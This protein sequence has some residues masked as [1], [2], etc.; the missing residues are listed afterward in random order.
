[1]RKN[2]NKISFTNLIQLTAIVLLCWGCGIFS[3]DKKFAYK[4]MSQITRIEITGDSSMSI[5]E[6]INNKWLVNGEYPANKDMM[7]NLTLVLSK[8]K[9]EYPLP[10]VYAQTLTD[11]L[12]IEKGMHIKLYAKTNLK[13]DFYILSSDSLGCIGLIN[14]EQQAY[15]LHMPGYNINL[16]DYIAPN[17]MFWLNNVL[18]SYYRNDI[19]SVEV[20]N[21]E[22]PNESFRID[23]MERGNYQLTDTQNLNI[24]QN[25]NDIAIKRYLTYFNTITFDSYAKLSE[26]EKKQLLSQQYSYK[27]T[28][29]SKKE[30][31]SYKIRYIL[32]PDS[33]LDIYGN[34]LKYDR[35]HF[36]ISKNDDSNIMVASWIT[37]DILLK[38]L[39]DFVNK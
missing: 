34:P 36:Y 28:I 10:R 25:I 17:Y 13:R 32:L 6:N 37:F 11:S 29:Q 30:K 3:S 35:Y 23:V 2:Y 18:F 7:S 31:N 19:M 16:R 1:M 27:L 15:M 9:V 21:K 20:E 26:V 14:G 22:H 38:N 4:R 33:E 5:L 39:S 8:L 12:I 24:V